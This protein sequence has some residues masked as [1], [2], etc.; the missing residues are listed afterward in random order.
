MIDSLAHEDLIKLVNQGKMATYS[1]SYWIASP[2]MWIYELQNNPKHFYRN[3]KGE[4]MWLGYKV[5]TYMTYSNDE[6]CFWSMV[7]KIIPKENDK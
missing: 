5:V 4:L 1:P 7:D 6:A 3:D 2:S